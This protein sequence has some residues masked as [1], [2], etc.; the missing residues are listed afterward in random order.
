MKKIVK[1]IEVT[2]PAEIYW[3]AR[4]RYK[5]AAILVAAY[6]TIVALLTLLA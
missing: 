6:Y 4:H 5:L 1:Q 3:V 2:S